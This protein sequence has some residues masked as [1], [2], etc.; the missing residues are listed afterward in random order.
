MFIAEFL[1]S[2]LENFSGAQ[3]TVKEQVGQ[4]LL[5]FIGKHRFEASPNLVA[6]RAILYFRNIALLEALRHLY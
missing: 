6:F 5:T 3:P 4:S 1:W 2:V